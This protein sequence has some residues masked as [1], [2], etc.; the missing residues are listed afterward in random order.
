MSATGHRGQARYERYALTYL[1]KSAGHASPPSPK[2]Q[3]I[4]QRRNM[5]DRM[6]LA[7]SKQGKGERQRKYGYV[8]IPPKL[9]ARGRRRGGRAVNG[10]QSYPRFHGGCSRIHWHPFVSP[11]GHRK[12]LASI[13]HPRHCCDSKL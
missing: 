3:T 11:P 6:T 8:P 1:P 4:E 12:P 10:G 7:C 5:S 2:G 9:S 13:V